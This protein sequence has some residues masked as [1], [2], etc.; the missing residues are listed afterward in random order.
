[1]DGLAVDFDKYIDAYERGISDKDYIVDAENLIIE[2]STSYYRNESDFNKQKK[3]GKSQRREFALPIDYG[4]QQR[5]QIESPVTYPPVSPTP[6]VTATTATTATTNK[7]MT[8]EVQEMPA[9]K[10]DDLTVNI[11]PEVFHNP[12]PTYVF[13]NVIS[14]Y[15]VADSKIDLINLAEAS[16]IAPML[17]AVGK[18][19][20]IPFALE[21]CEIGE[22]RSETCIDSEVWGDMCPVEIKGIGGAKHMVNLPS[23]SGVYV[24]PSYLSKQIGDIFILRNSSFTM[25]LMMRK[26]SGQIEV[27]HRLQSPTGSTYGT[28]IHYGTIA[29]HKDTIGE[30]WMLVQRIT[31]GWHIPM[32]PKTI[33]TV[34]TGSTQI[35]RQAI[36]TPV[37]DARVSTKEIK[38]TA[39]RSEIAKSETPLLPFV[40][41]AIDL[42]Q[43]SI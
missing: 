39:V 29:S 28:V 38:A 18:S 15:V 4:K 10:L 36:V 13:Q 11:S 12:A 20:F 6:I 42:N 1:L 26:D 35:T 5:K 37:F 21:I 41:K 17:K 40:G 27:G 7:L 33:K 24:A 8:T 19:L 32:K 14:Q 43:M 2:T 25:D 30:V 16:V 9:I 23:S 31:D 22:I 3:R 34:L